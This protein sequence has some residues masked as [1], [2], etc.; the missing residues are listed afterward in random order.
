MDYKKN[1]SIA[2]NNEIYT[3][4][5]TIVMDTRVFSK[6]SIDDEIAFYENSLSLVKIQLYGTDVVLSIRN[7]EGTIKYMPNK[8]FWREWKKNFIN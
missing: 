4:N 8:M 1:T 6:E 7:Y 2:M 3:I 5:A